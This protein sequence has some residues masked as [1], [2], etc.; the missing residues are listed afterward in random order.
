MDDEISI[1][2]IVSTFLNGDKSDER[3][4]FKVDK[5]Q[6]VERQEPESSNDHK[7]LSMMSLSSLDFGSTGANGQLI[8]MDPKY[9]DKNNS[10]ENDFFYFEFEMKKV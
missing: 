5:N 3:L 7:K 8:V 6:Q 4:Y 9:P 10:E 1:M 2:D